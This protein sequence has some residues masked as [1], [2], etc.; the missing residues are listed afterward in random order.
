AR[1]EPD[2]QGMLESLANPIRRA[3][4]AYVFSSGPAAYSS[5]LKMNFVDSSSKLSFHLQKLQADRLLEKNP[6][7]AYALTE[8]GRRAWR[9]VR[10]LS[11]ER[12]RPAVLFEPS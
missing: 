6:E 2:L 3:I 4:V 9:V 10:A 11:D 7:G 1:A 12:H 8:D 5:I